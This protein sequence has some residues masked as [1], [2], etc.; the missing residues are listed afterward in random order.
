MILPFRKFFRQS[1]WISSTLT[2]LEKIFRE[3]S[4]LKVKFVVSLKVD[5]TEVLL[6]NIV[7]VHFFRETN[8]NLISRFDEIFLI[9]T[10][11]HREMKV[12]QI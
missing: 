7:K 8:F 1:N 3:I 2:H 6:E 11:F 10:T 4:L 9:F 5:F 12:L